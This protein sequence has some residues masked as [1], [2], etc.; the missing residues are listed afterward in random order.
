MAL[1]QIAEPGMS[2]VPHQHNYALGIDLGTTNSLVACVLSGETKVF[3]DINGSRLLPS[4][5]YYNEDSILVGKSA[6]DKYLISPENTI[7][8][9]KR[10]LGKSLKSV[11]SDS[12]LPYDFA[13]SSDMPQIKT[14]Q[15][16]K[17][18]TEISAEI[19]KR[20]SSIASLYLEENPIG[21]VITVPAYFDEGQRQATKNAAQLANLNVLRLLS[22]PTAAAIAYGLENK[23]QG[24]FI[25]YDLGGGTF[26]VSILELHNGVFEV[27]SV[28]G[29]TKLGGDDFDH[30]LYCYILEVSGISVL[31]NTDHAKVLAQ[32]KLIKEQLS[33]LDKVSFNLLLSTKQL[34][35][36]TITREDF[37]RISQ[38]L[39]DNTINLLK[40]ALR[41]AK[42]SLDDIDDVILVGGSTRMPIIKNA[43]VKLIGKPALDD[44]NPDEVVAI[45]AAM[46]A[47]LLAGNVKDDWLLLDVTPLSLGVETM[48]GLVEKIIPRNSAIPTK[49]AQD[50]TTYKDGQTAM[51]VH[52]VQGEREKV[53][54]C[55]S[56]A[57]FTLRGIPPIVA[58]AAKIRVTYQIDADGLL[59]VSA[60][61]LTSGVISSLEVK[62]SNNLSVEQIASILT[63]SISSSR[64][65]MNYRKQ[66]E[67]EI[68]IRSLIA[69]IERNIAQYPQLLSIAENE[70][71]VEKIKELSELIAQDEYSEDN[72]IKTKRCYDDLNQLTSGFAS[73]IMNESIKHS[74]QGKQ[75]TKITDDFG[76]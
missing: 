5:V 19:L 64:D 9:V 23:K 76:L 74:L 29:D 45:G 44:F 10:M 62:P 70:V 59:S 50:F 52:I 4:V 72:Y 55:I 39:V 7:V 38:K 13:T 2:G 15:G 20:L 43:L 34:I 8:S 21:V 65:D 32:A 73:K 1:L 61:E 63:D 46:Q 40:K 37:V 17:T 68:D 24:K 3:A 35:N 54:D 49:M 14:A 66:K 33:T 57:K 28:N 56:L 22:E 25:V 51:S 41:D 69:G 16:Y 18:P 67:L 53:S 12:L 36:L 27:L 75:I 6:Y 58:G 42:L 26:D 60:Q 48:G 11:L 30:R 31:N 47:N 71:F